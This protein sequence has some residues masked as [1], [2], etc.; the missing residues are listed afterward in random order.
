MYRFWRLPRA[1]PAK[2]LKSLIKNKSAGSLPELVD[3]QT[4][5]VRSDEF[6]KALTGHIALD[7]SAAPIRRA[8]DA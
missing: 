7:T 5:G 1:A 6:S 8:R 2:L 4:T 3:V